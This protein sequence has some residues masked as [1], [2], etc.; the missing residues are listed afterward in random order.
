[1]AT[2]AIPTKTDGTQRYT[3]RTSLG[4]NAYGFEFFW[5]PRDSSWSFILSDSNGGEIVERKVTLGSL[6]LLKFADPRLPAGELCAIDTSGQDLDAGLTDL[7]GRVLLVFTDAA[8][9]L[10]LIA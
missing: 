2:V 1:M 3:L 10:A 5:N 4:G 7:G 9:I 6:M 8:D